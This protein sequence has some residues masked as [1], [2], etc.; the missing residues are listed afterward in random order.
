MLLVTLL[1][2]NTLV[3][4]SLPILFDY[5][6]LTGA[7]AVAASTVLVLVF[8]EI[9]P[10]AVCS[11]YGLQIGAFFA[12]PVRILIFILYPVVFP[13][14]S[15]LDYLLGHTKGMVFRYK[16]FNPRHA[17][18]K[19]LVTLHGP[20]TSGPLT[21]DEVSIIKAVLDL[22]DK[23]VSHIMTKIE[24]VFMLPL[25][26]TLD[27]AT[28]ALISNAGHSR[29]PIYLPNDRN[30]IAGVVLVKQLILNQ[31]QTPKIESLDLRI[32]PRVMHDLALYEMLHVFQGGSS[33]M[34]VVVGQTDQSLPEIYHTI[35]IVTLEDVIEELLGME[36]IDETDV[37][38][39]MSSKDLVRRE[40]PLLSNNTIEAHFTDLESQ[41]LLRPAENQ[42]KPRFFT[43][44]TLPTSILLK[45]RELNGSSTQLER[46]KN[47]ISLPAA[48][49]AEN[50]QSVISSRLSPLFANSNAEFI[51]VKRGMSPFSSSDDA[52]NVPFLDLEDQV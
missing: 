17:E 43:Q 41:S 42:Q 21:H 8:G 6:Q 23:T 32:L 4:E 37:Y 50:P 22:R 52:T 9:I 51:A 12:W 28:M 11:R 26:A 24:N 49:L 47:K 16:N 20:D 27:R 35:G 29:V 30:N 39:D 36:L 25:D 38:V 19:Q 3:N 18:I 48:V 1:I 7:S 33:H 44:I 13:I 14:S 40:G 15:L 46:R 45:K 5:I 31:G 34:A 10:Q 2:I